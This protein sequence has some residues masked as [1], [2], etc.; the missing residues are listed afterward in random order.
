MPGPIYDPIDVHKREIRILILLPSRRSNSSLK[1]E[2]LH[3]DL[4]ALEDAPFNYYEAVSY[5]WGDATDRVRIKLNG[6]NCFITKNLHG[7]LTR[8]RAKKTPGYYW[9]DAV[10]ID[11]ENIPERGQQVQLMKAIY[12]TAE[13]VLVWLGPS[14][15]DSDVAMDFVDEMTDAERN[16]EGIMP[17]DDDEDAAIER[18]VAWLRASLADPKSA[19]KWRALARL[20]LRPW[21]KRV[22]IRQEVAV[23]SDVQ[24]LC[25]NDRLQ[26]WPT[27]VMAAE[28]VERVGEMFEPF[29]RDV[30][31]YCADRKWEN[32]GEGGYQV[33]G[34]YEVIKLDSLRES[35]RDRGSADEELLFIQSRSCD[36]TDPRDR[37]FGLVGLAD[38]EAREAIVPDYTLSSQDVFIM[39][40]KR[41][42]TRSGKVDC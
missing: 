9:V 6:H 8:L 23:A 32:G 13:Q 18:N 2:L 30:G 1:C 12:E 29:V 19:R 11:Q 38:Q 4:D 20:F 15:E 22:W 39:A 31:R 25:G 26:P 21:W 5:T 17:D 42:L 33:S 37:I 36:A 10:C 35:L 27:L 41:L 3:V 7:L 34:F 14:S 16:D 24:V 28:Y 40:T